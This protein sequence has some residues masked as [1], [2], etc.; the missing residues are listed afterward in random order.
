MALYVCKAAERLLSFKEIGLHW[1]PALKVPLHL[2]LIIRLFVPQNLISNQDSPVPL[3]E[4]QMAPRFKTLMC[5]G[6]RNKPIYT[7]LFSRKVQI[8]EAPLCYVTRPQRREITAYR[9]FL[10]LSWYISIY[11][12]LR[13][14]GKIVPPRSLTGSQCTGILRHQNQIFIYLFTYSFI[15][16]RM[17]VGITEN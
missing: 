11:L 15:H 17:S 8:N 9:I 3:P 7:I 16:S 1:V 5:S 2:G 10:R 14:P 13:F 12:S 6:S 4:L